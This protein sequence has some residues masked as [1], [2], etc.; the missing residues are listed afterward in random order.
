MNIGIWINAQPLGGKGGLISL[1][2]SLDTG[3]RSQS[4]IS[5]E[6]P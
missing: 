2:D 6:L 5:L 4:G 1:D 3:R